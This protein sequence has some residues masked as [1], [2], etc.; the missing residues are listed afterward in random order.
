VK[1]GDFMNI[2]TASMISETL[3]E[4]EGQKAMV[5]IIADIINMVLH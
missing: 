1:Y 2:R 5:V 3:G 4:Q